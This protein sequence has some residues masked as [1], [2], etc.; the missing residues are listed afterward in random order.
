[1]NVI[2]TGISECRKNEYAK[3]AQKLAKRNGKELRLYS[4]GS[5][6]SRVLQQFCHVTDEHILNKSDEVLAIAAGSAIKDLRIKQ[7]E[8]QLR[9][10]E[11][12]QAYAA[13]V[14]LVST[15]ATFPWKNIERKSHNLP[16]LPDLDP[17]LFIT[18]IDME[19]TIEERL[20]KNKQWQS[21]D[22]SLEE[23]SKW[24]DREI[25]ETQE[26]ARLYGRHILLSRNQSAETLYRVLFYPT[27]PLFYL[28]F[29]M[30]HVQKQAEG[31]KEINRLKEGMERYGPV[32]DPRTGDVRGET[33]PVLLDQTTE[34]DRIYSTQC[35]INTV[36]IAENVFTV[37]A[38]TELIKAHG[39][40]R[41]THLIF[42]KEKFPDRTPG[43]FERFYSTK[44]FES[45]ES[46]L[47]YL[48]QEYSP[49]PEID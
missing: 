27:A 1:M 23:I 11:K 48:A 20:K 22:L 17:E 25:K 21:Q 4:V 49:L 18:I 36:Y 10:C 13:P 45:I 7:L 33:N 24:Q 14:T 30:S 39:A 40:S 2:L 32:V 6:M 46:Y 12:Q 19:R 16:Y 26:W 28:S 5:E 38:V 3:E 31:D 37:G 34:R 9:A 41:K 47:E 8:E 42:P 29:A 43:P 44:I 35:D 15:H